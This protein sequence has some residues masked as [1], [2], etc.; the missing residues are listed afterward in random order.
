MLKTKN[1]IYRLI[2]GIPKKGDRFNLSKNNCQ[3]I[4]GYIFGINQKKFF[5]DLEIYEIYILD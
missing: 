2:G 5:L 3:N 4:K 1:N